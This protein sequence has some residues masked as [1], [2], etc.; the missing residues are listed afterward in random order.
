VMLVADRSESIGPEG[1]LAAMHFVHEAWESR[2]DARVGLIAFDGT[3]EVRRPLDVA[4]LDD[5][6][7]KYGVTP[8]GPTGAPGTHI[9]AAVRLAAA[10]L[11]DA[12]ER[13][14]VLLSDGRATRGD[15]L[16]EVRRAERAGIVVDTVPVGFAS[17]KLTLARVSARELR[18][19]DG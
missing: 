2:G 19:A 7:G 8:L 10:A 3:A 13:R 5:S 11:P 14:I 16:A 17:D 18:V 12:G 9:A 6:E 4:S 15:A 1:R